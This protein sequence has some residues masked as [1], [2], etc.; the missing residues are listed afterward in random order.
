MEGEKLEDR[1][2]LK[3]P[4]GEGIFEKGRLSWGGGGRIWPPGVTC[5]LDRR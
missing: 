1:D 3:M 2:I 5:R 4:E